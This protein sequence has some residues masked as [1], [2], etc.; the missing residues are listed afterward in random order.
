MRRVTIK[1]TVTNV[2]VLAEDRLLSQVRTVQC[3][4]GESGRTNVLL[5]YFS[6]IAMLGL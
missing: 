2:W 6:Y 5:H 1:P 4:Q 3:S